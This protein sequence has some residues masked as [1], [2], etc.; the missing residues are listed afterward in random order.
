MF[1]PLIVNFPTK[2]HW[3]AA[4][5]IEDVERG[6]K[7]LTEKYKE[8]GIESIAVP[9]LGCGNGQLLWESVGPL[10][11][12]YVSQ[13]DIPVTIYAPYGTPQGQLKVEFFEAGS[14]RKAGTG[15]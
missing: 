14:V 12:K 7:I 8:W 15:A 5:R 2:S 11:Y 10:I 3:R 1:S 13:W 4:S 9:P 6:L